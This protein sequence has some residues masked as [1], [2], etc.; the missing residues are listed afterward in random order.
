MY[1]F[2]E[3]SKKI[4]A[5]AEHFKGE[6]AGIRT[7]RAAPGLLDAVR[8]DAYGTP[9]PLN[10]V[11]NVSI[12]DARTLRVLPWDLGLV[13]AVEKAIGDASLGVSV[14]SDERGVR[15][16]FPELT[17]E[18][19]EQL[20]KLTRAKLEESRVALRQHRDL[21]WN[22]IQQQQK[23]GDLTEDEKFTGKEEMERLIKEGNQTLEELAKKKEEELR[24]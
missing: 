2:T 18:R 12:E 9:M 4:A 23:S 19:R 7:G 5:T 1:T 16:T 3:L 8:V 17:A 21:V 22:D 15:V 13:K 24:A 10:Q 14:G 20:V 6:L 11:G